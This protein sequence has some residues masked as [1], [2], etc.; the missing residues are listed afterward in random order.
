MNATGGTLVTRVVVLSLLCASAHVAGAQA[1]EAYSTM[2]PVERYL[3]DRT[4]EIALARSAAPPS[5]SKDATIVLLGRQGYETAVPGTNGF[6]CGVERSWMNL[7]DSP[8]FWNPKVRGAI[9]YNAAAA[10]SV[11]PL[12]FL[13]A[14]LVLEGLPKPEIIDRIKTAYTKKQLVPVEP[15]AMA[16]MQ[17]QRAYLT[18]Q[19]LTEDGAHSIAHVMVYTPLMDGKSWGADLPGSPVYTVP[20]F[21]GAPE[22]IDIFIVMT[23]FWSDGTSAPLKFKSN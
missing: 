2:A 4:D 17:A 12:V 10:R 18:D 14:K 16:Y 8:E 23:G 20:A 1:R 6:V 19:A 22:P 3:M 15:G 9:C 5:I 11:L 7:F 13:R 21:N